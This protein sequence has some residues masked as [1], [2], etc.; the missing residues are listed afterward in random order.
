MI[1]QSHR[2][3]HPKSFR[4]FID[5][6]IA[7]ITRFLLQCLSFGRTESTS[8]LGA[9]GWWLQKAVLGGLQTAASVQQRLAQL[10]GECCIQ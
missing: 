1:N 6:R 4:Q 10:M 9:L 5:P 7:I 8:R 2:F 3:V